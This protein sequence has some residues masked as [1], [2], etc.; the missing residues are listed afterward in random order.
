VR[1]RATPSATG[2]GIRM[3]EEAGAALTE[4][5]G[6]YGH[7]L[8]RDAMTDD[9]LWP[10]PNIDVCATAAI[11]VDGTGKRFVDEGRGAVFVTNAIARLPD[12]LSATVVMNQRIWEEVGT[13][14][15]APPNGNLVE[16]GGT[17]IEA[18]DLAA[19]AARIGVPPDALAETV[20]GYN[21]A[22]DAGTPDRLDPTRSTGRHTA[23]RIDDGPYLAIPVCAGL[24]N[25]MGGI[26][27]DAAARVLDNADAPLPG[28]YAAG[29]STGGLEGGPNVG[30]VG[31]I[32]KA[33][34]LGLIAGETAAADVS[35]A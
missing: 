21:A 18:P 13:S 24:T 33:F 17:L 5:A 27:I 12:P 15:V 9:R 29:S 19:L 2:D 4:L 20:A 1:L 6:F 28:L 11:V 34:I 26:R 35:A 32:A 7:V 22:L 16:N 30:Y 10:Y 3:A 14:G 8:S 31:G 25:T 23:H